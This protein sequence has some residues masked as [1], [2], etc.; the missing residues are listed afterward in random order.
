MPVP[1]GAR[2]G[3]DATMETMTDRVPV[4]L[5]RIENGGTVVCRLDNDEGWDS[6]R[7]EVEAFYDEA[8]GANAFVGVTILLG[9]WTEADVESLPEYDGW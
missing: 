7:A 5:L 6:L 9:A 2:D 3:S 8:A 4:A 1:S